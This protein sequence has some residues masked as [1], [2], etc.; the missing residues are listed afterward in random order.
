MKPSALKY[1]LITPARNEEAYI[2]LT[3]LSVIKQ[4]IRPVR[5]VIL[6]DGSTDRTDEIAQKYAALHDWIDFHRLPQRDSRDFAGKARG[7]NLGY[8]RAKHLEHDL[9]CSLD[10]DIS[11]DEGYFEF[12]LGKFDENPRLGLGGT[13]YSE[14]GKT[15]DYRFASIEHVSGACQMFRRES[16]EAIGG[17]VPVKGGGIDLIAV[18][19]VRMKGWET[20]TFP[21]VVCIHH[22]PMGSANDKNVIVSTFKLGER[23]Y[24]LGFHPLWQIFRS[25]NYMRKKPYLVG[26]C[27]LGSGYFWAWLRRVERPISP[28]LKEFQQRDQMKRLRHFFGIGRKTG[29][30]S[31]R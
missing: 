14:N 3:I 18:L 13:P 1:I 6:S 23:G 5:W 25:V 4:T 28:E 12:L 2:E 27:A 9:V 26:G 30:P 8:E 10:A 17:Y 31:S 29:N 15:Y 21:E 22:R 24:R 19:S 7:F 11:F 20:R 16:F